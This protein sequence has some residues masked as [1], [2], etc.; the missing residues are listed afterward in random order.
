MAR[1][2]R[3]PPENHLFVFV[4]GEITDIDPGDEIDVIHEDEYEQ[5]TLTM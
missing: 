1:M 2:A 4:R 3:H 5:D